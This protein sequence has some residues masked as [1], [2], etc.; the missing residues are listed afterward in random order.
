MIYNK[1]ILEAITKGIKLA[2]DDYQDTEDNS[3]VSSKSDI[4]RNE[5][6]MEKLIKHYD[7]CVDLGLPSGNIWSKYNLGVNSKILNTK[8]DYIGNYYAWGETKPKRKYTSDN[9]KFGKVNFLTGKKSDMDMSKYNKSS[10]WLYE[11]EDVDDVAKQI[12]KSNWC[13]PCIKDYEELMQYTKQKFVINY[14]DIKDLH[15]VTFIGSNKNSIFV[16]LSGEW[17]DLRGGITGQHIIDERYGYFWLSELDYKR[18]YENIACKASVCNAGQC[19]NYCE[20]Y[21]GLPIRPIY[22]QYEN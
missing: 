3:S 9:Y 22:K 5:N 18:S 2:L 17:D 11:L 21:I 12:L 7:L 8:Q 10:D 15:G 1:H 4:I 16:P 20:R 6:T 14:N 13:I 19:I